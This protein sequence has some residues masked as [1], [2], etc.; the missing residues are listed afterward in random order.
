MWSHIRLQQYLGCRMGD[1]S[2]KEE[3]LCFFLIKVYSDLSYFMVILSSQK[4]RA[5]TNQSLLST[6]I[7]SL[8]FR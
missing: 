4:I 6:D 1:G 2:P 8:R 5:K 3:T 7:S